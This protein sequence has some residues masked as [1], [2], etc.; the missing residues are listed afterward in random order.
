MP[1]S[2]ERRLEDLYETLTRRAALLLT[3]ERPSHTLEPA[4]L[5]NEAWIRVSSS[6]NPKL[7]DEAYLFASVVRAM[8]RVL[9]DHARDRL[10]L[11]RG[12]P[13]RHR[14]S[15]TSRDFGVEF[16]LDDMID[17]DAALAELDEIDPD[18]AKVVEL[19]FLGGL[20]VEETAV[21][22]G[23]SPRTVKRDWAWA[24]AWLY[25]R[26]RPDDCEAED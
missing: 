20:T 6:E 17:F 12:G 13:R 8:R 3:G 18:V 22:V 11:R 4:A 7:E 14:V 16:E 23:C 1:D 25:R 15:L 5:V 21:V 26:L 19:R 10:T 24:R 9:V 2:Q